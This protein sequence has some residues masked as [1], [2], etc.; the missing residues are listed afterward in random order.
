MDTEKQT[1]IH[2]ELAPLLTELPFLLHRALGEKLVGIYLYG[3]VVTGDFDPG[4]SDV[5]LL[6]AIAEPLN[7]DEFQRLDGVHTALISAFPHWSDRLEILYYPLEG[8][9]TFRTRRSPIAVISPGEPF[10]RKDA[11]RDWLMNWYLVRR[12]GHTLFGPEPATL[13][14]PIS[15]AEFIASVREHALCW[16][17]WLEQTRADCQYQAY[18]VLTLCR[19]LYT[20]THGAHVSK[21][22]AIHWVA[23]RW[24]GWAETV[25]RALAWRASLP[26]D[27][28]PATSYVETARF[29]EWAVSELKR[30]QP[31]GTNEVS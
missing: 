30:T 10:N 24:P 15:D 11:G 31:Q 12:M 22:A 5:D 26:D 25:L 16:P 23:S 20:A 28:E 19:T 14:E 29:V 18:A 3:S 27:A 21:Q 1:G 6:A 13:I 2:E 8:L 7:D 9:R 4:L 17:D